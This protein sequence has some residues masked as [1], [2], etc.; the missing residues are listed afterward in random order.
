[1]KNFS[2]LLCLALGCSIPGNAPSGSFPR[3]FDAGAPA[4]TRTPKSFHVLHYALALSFDEDAGGVVG[5]ETIEFEALERPLRF[6]ALDAEGLQVSSVEEEPG[7][8]LRFETLATILSIDLGS[9]LEP[10]RARRLRI[11]YRAFPKRGLHFVRAGGAGSRKTAQIW[12][13]GEQTDSHFWFPCQDRPDDLASTEVTGTVR[14]PEALVSNGRLLGVEVHSDSKTRTFHWKIDRP[15]SVYL[16][17]IVVGTFTELS[18]ARGGVPLSY[19]VPPWVDRETAMRSFGRTGDMLEFFSREFGVE[20]PFPRYS[21]T[22]VEEFFEGMENVGATTLGEQLFHCAE[23]EPEENSENLLAHELAHQWFGDLVTCGAWSE[24]WLNEAFADFSAGLWTEHSR[25][26]DEY[27]LEMLA[28]EHAFFEEDRTRYRRP[29]VAAS[30]FDTSELFDRVAYDKGNWVLAMLRSAVGDR[31]FFRGLEI[32]L[33]TNAGKNVATGDLQKAMEEASGRGLGGF[34]DEWVRSAGY[35]EYAVSSSYDAQRHL[36]RV[37]VDQLQDASRGAPLFSMPVDLDFETPSGFEAH[38]LEL[39]S[40]HEEFSFPAGRAPKLVR[41]DPGNRV[42]KLV[43]FEKPREEL[44]EQA[45]EDPD[46]TGRIWAAGELARRFADSRTAGDLAA[47]ESSDPFYGVRAAAAELLEDFC[48][49]V[50]SDAL[51][52]GLADADSRVRGA[53]AGSLAGCRR[54]GDATGALARVLETDPSGW[55]AGA[56]A[57]AIGKLRA[58]EAFSVLSRALAVRG[59]RA[60]RR[61]I[62]A[63]LAVIGSRESREQIVRACSPDQPESTRLAA[64]AALG[65]LP[66]SDSDAEET[67]EKALA[68]TDL[69]AQTQAVRALGELKRD[70]AVPALRLAAERS[71]LLREEVDSAIRRIGERKK[72]EGIS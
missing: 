54:A 37:T 51:R 33:R 31:D 39:R 70:R 25:G 19:F 64:I 55:V 38:R 60:A 42:L 34:F 47:I 67:L 45:R 1:M 26:E 36:V 53:A 3:V 48:D 27:R 15:H 44:R 56:A 9:E 69:L 35:P 8:R 5:S 46:V 62:L 32:Y 71:P 18:E 22:A 41:F 2:I 24:V 29:L 10:G 13:Q 4:E 43:R 7:K 49:P 12:S 66:K 59:E 28:A 58:P 11:D 72:R 17:S 63:G 6:L 14:E 16:T 30:Y 50:A 68:D 52:R 40:R 65:R 61:G 23:A 20:F 57:E 21:Q